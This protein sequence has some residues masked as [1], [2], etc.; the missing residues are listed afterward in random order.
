MGTFSSSALLGRVFLTKDRV[1]NAPRSLWGSGEVSQ[2]SSV[3]AWPAKHLEVV[4]A[5]WASGNVLVDDCADFGLDKSVQTLA[6]DMR[7]FRNCA[8]LQR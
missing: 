7:G 6:E 8:R 4:L 2:S 3:V 5:L 1:D